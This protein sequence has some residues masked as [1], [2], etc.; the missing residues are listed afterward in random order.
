MSKKE[1]NRGCGVLGG[2]KDSVTTLLAA[3]IGVV[4]VVLGVILENRTDLLDRIIP[5]PP[6]RVLISDF[7]DPGLAFSPDTITNRNCNT[8]VLTDGVVRINPMTNKQEECRLALRPKED[9]IYNELG[10]VEVTL[11]MDDTEETMESSAYIEM[12]TYFPGVQ[13]KIHCG[14]RHVNNELFGFLSIKT[15]RTGNQE[16]ICTNGILSADGS[17]CAFG[18]LR[19]AELHPEQSYSF[20]LNASHTVNE[21]QCFVNDRYTQYWVDTTAEQLSSDLVNALFERYL[22]VEHTANSRAVYTIDNVYEIR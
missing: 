6:S 16:L 1:V 14:M 11:Q 2:C 18:P 20:Q 21:F 19:F 13:L 9:R 15:A 4:G 8:L 10:A 7:N 17:S 12:I 5:P 3:I 22:I